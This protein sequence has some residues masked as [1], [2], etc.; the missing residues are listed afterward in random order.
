MYEANRFLKM[1]PDTEDTNHTVLVGKTF[2][3]ENDSSC[4]IDSY[5][6]Y[7]RSHTVHSHCKN[8]QS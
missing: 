3:G 7:G 8:Q 1:S 5:S 6:G 2:N 4:I